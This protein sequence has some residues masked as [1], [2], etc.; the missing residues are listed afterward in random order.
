MLQREYD[1]FLAHPEIVGRYAGEYI[2]IVGEKIVAHGRDLKTI[3]AEAEKHGKPLVHKVAPAN[4]E[5]V[6]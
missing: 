3:F 4:K 6:V 5:L 1:W 2:A